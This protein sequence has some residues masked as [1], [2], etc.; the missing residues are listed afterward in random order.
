[1]IEPLVADRILSRLQEKGTMAGLWEVNS[2]L[3]DKWILFNGTS[4]LWSKDRRKK[5]IGLLGQ[6]NVNTTV[7]GN[8]IE[9]IYIISQAAN[10]GGAG[11]PYVADRLKKL[12][13]DKEV[14]G[15]IW[16]AAT[17]RPVQ[18]RSLGSMRE[19]RQQFIKICGSA[20]HLPFPKWL[21]VGK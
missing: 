4:P 15:A 11:I 10:V 19:I 13:A 14:S 1:E 12:L 7:H 6:A 20:E 16:K 17:A 2:N 3:P 8:V 18:Y 9:L 21:E 5:M